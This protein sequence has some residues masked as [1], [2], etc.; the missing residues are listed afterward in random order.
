MES[1]A[2]VEGPVRITGRW[3][4]A[5]PI[6]ANSSA[7]ACDV[8]RIGP[9][10]GRRLE[11]PQVEDDCLYRT[12]GDFRVGHAVG[13]KA[14]DLTIDGIVGEDIGGD[15]HVLVVCG[16]G[17]V[18]QG[19]R[20]SLLAEPAD[21]LS[22]HRHPR[23]QVAVD[24]V[25]DPADLGHNVGL[26]HQ[27]DPAGDPVPIQIVRVLEVEQGLIGDGLEVTQPGDDRRRELG[28]TGHPARHRLQPCS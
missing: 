4:L 19:N 15:P 7:P 1:A 6:F 28:I 20:G 11:G 23:R 16:D 14:S 26:V 2:I 10:A 9:A 25:L 22:I 12:R 18:Q 3:H 13:G 21:Q 17:L 27:L 8:G 5:Q 24:H